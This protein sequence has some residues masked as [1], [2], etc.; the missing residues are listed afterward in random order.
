MHLRFFSRPLLCSLD[1][2][3]GWQDDI[4]AAAKEAAEAAEQILDTTKAAFKLTDKPSVREK[5]KQ[6]VKATTMATA[7]LLEAAKLNNKAGQ[8]TDAQQQIS[9]VSQEVAERINDYVAAARELPGASK[10]SLVEDF[11]EDLDEIAEKE[12]RNAAAVIERAAAS[13]LSSR[14]RNEG[15]VDINY[16]DLDIT[17][18]I[19]EAARAIALAT[20]TLVKAAAA[21]QRERVLAGRDPKTKHLYKKVPTTLAI[22]LLLL[23]LL[24]IPKNL[25]I[26]SCSND[27]LLRPG[28]G[29]GKWSH[30]GG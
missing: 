27:S 12:L 11:G 26:V 25:A 2:L 29:L 30:L 7:K 15:V 6:T 5:L 14:P 22:S 10:L 23:F 16:D 4:A 18:A 21:A 28:P 13:I 1:L 8:K 19:L 9:A 3:N 20:S 24:L 17:E